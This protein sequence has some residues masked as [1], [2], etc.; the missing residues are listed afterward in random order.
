MKIRISLA[1][2]LI[3]ACGGGDAS[4]QGNLAATMPSTGSSGSEDISSTDLML[5]DVKSPGR[6]IS[7]YDTSGDERPDIRK[8]FQS[9][10]EGAERRLILVCRESD[11]KR[12]WCKRCCTSLQSRRASFA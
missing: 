9:V 1:L 6:E 2:A 4:V 7:E 8:V 3:G 5:C 12:R 11:L 10:G